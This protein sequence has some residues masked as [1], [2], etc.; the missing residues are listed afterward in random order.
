MFYIFGNVNLGTHAR[1][2]RCYETYALPQEFRW[3]FHGIALGLFSVG[4]E[5]YVAFV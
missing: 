3:T 5:A 1:N 2:V 4:M